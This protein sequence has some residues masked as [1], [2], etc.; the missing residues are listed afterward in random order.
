MKECV[1]GGMCEEG[2]GPWPGKGEAWSGGS[3]MGTV[4]RLVVRAVVMTGM[5][6]M[7]CDEPPWWPDGDW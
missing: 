7:L 3:W 2:G 5:C 1:A 6:E 4:M